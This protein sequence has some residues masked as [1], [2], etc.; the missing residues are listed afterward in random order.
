M[1][2]SSDD[3]FYLLGWVRRVT[4][5]RWPNKVLKKLIRVLTSEKWARLQVTQLHKVTEIFFRRKNNFQRLRANILTWQF[6]P[7]KLFYW[8]ILYVAE[9]MF[10]SIFVLHFEVEFQITAMKFIIFPFEEKFSDN[11][12]LFLDSENKNVLHSDEHQCLSWK[13]KKYCFKSWQNIT[14]KFTFST[15]IDE[16]WI[17]ID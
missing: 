17:L 6:H 1:K 16:S 12:N 3:V 4:A 10:I 14:F 2:N 9:N 15:E 5:L 8:K 13:T 11:K 7:K